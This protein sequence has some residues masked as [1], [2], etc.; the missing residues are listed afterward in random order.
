M[1]KKESIWFESVP[2]KR[3]YPILKTSIK[4]DV[5]VIGGGIVGI[6]TACKLVDAGFS[7][8]LLEKNHLVTGDSG[9]TTAFVTRVL[10]ATSNDIE[11]LYG[12][13]FLEKISK[14]MRLSQLQIFNYVK[15]IS[16]DFTKCNSYFCDYNEE[17][18]MLN[19]W[20][21]VKKFDKLAELI[22]TNKKLGISFANAIKFKDEGKF[23]I[24][25]YLFELLKH[26]NIHVFEESKVTKIDSN[27]KV[28]VTTEN[29]II[30]ADKAVVC[31][32]DP[33]Y[34]LPELKGIIKPMITYVS[35]L[36][37]KHSPL[38]KD[39]FYDDLNPYFYYRNI[40]GQNLMIGGS[41]QEFGE[42][43]SEK[44]HAALKKFAFKKFGKG[45]VTHEWSGSVFKTKDEL[46]YF[47]EHKNNI[48]VVTGF[49]GNGIVCGN[50]ASMIVSDLVMGK[51][52]PYAA[53][54]SLKRTK[55]KK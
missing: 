48:F 12:K 40:D 2:D 11:K 39:I 30:T 28:I 16:C 19:E 17:K 32:G 52:N 18:T 27:K 9:F 26:K 13:E 24:R 54:F 7:V 15:R 50:L 41:D 55:Q 25:R 4:A 45:T 44:A 49:D 14:A 53:L 8:A 42:L 29:G 10:D 31:V 33:T 3:R 43:D 5:V 37:Y 35:L 47:F 21:H 46:P 6:S 51:K 34:L 36:K 38:S 23:N 1:I 20:K 22:T